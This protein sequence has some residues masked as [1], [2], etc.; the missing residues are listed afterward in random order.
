M[1]SRKSVH[2]NHQGR[3]SS[4]LK[5]EKDDED[6]DLSSNFLNFLKKS[7][8][9]EMEQ[10]NIEEE[11]E[12]DEGKKAEDQNGSA[13]DKKNPNLFEEIISGNF[14]KEST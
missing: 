5:A 13:A 4:L 3:K 9:E 7:K 10:E 8:S 14:W 2:L 6:D 1:I 12:V 11:E